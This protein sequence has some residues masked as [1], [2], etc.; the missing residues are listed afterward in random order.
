[1]HPLDIDAYWIQRKLSKYYKDSIK[2]QAKANDVMD[3]L[4]NAHDDLDFENRL[5]LELGRECFD[6]IR[7]LKKHRQMSKF[8]ASCS[9][10]NI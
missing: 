3:I 1:M 4:Q 5:V 10:N 7:I 9:C 6:F 8:L 2:S